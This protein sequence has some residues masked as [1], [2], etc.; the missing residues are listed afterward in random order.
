M[1]TEAFVPDT[2]VRFPQPNVMRRPRAS[3]FSQSSLPSGG[4]FQPARSLSFRSLAAHAQSTT[5]SPRSTLD[6][7]ATGSP[8]PPDIKLFEQLVNISQQ[9]LDTLRNSNIVEKGPNDHQSRFWAVYQKVAA[10]HDDEFFERHDN[11]M[12]IILTFSGLFSAVNTAFITNMGPSNANTTNALLTQIIVLM[13]KESNGTSIGDIYPLP[14][15]PA[16][17]SGQVWFQTLAYASLSFSLLAAFGAVLGK[18]WLRFYKLERCGRGSLVERGKNRQQKLEG[19]EAWHFDAVL[20]MFPVLLQISLLLFGISLSSCVWTQQQTITAIV[21]AT[22]VFGCLFYAFT[23]FASLLSPLCPFQT[24]A[25]FKFLR[26]AGTFIGAG[27]MFIENVAD[28]RHSTRMGLRSFLQSFK[29]SIKTSTSRF[30]QYLLNSK[31]SSDPAT[32]PAVKWVLATSTDPDDIAAAAALIPTITWSPDSNNMSYYQRLRD[33]FVGCFETDGR[34]RPSAEARAVDC[35]RA[36][37]HLCVAGVPIGDESTPRR[38]WHQWRNIVLPQGFEQCKTL[39][40]QLSTSSDR[41]RC[42]ADTRTA[43]RMM[44]AAAGDGFIPPDSE[45]IIWRGRFTWSGDHRTSADF[46]WLV[47]YLV[48]CSKDSTTMADA[49]LAL[50]AMGGLG[51]R[52]RAPAYLEA[53]ISAMKSDSPHRLRYAALRAVSDSR[54]ALADINAIEGEKIRESLLTKLSPALLMA[55]RVENEKNYWRDDAYLRLI[56]A[57]ASNEQ[58]CRQLVADGHIEQCIFMLNNLDERSSA[59]LHLSAVFGRLC[60]TCPDAAAFEAVAHAQFSRLAKLAWQSV[61]D[62]KLYD[63]DESIS[64]LPAVVTFT[65]QK[66]IVADLKDIRRNVGLA[67][68]KLKRRNTRSEIMSVMQDYYTSMLTGLTDSDT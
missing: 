26:M 27:C 59:P 4:P 67:M 20:Q 51:S 50:S 36:L 3:G 14:V 57:L 48:Y 64:A 18:Q 24:P 43:L 33:T 45:S 21:I 58:W 32:E 16:Y 68:D 25:S 15:P 28:L 46:D 40:C 49:F 66:I 11:D 53:L 8:Y 34:L 12:D 63:E 13:A 62:L 2:N 22:T 61:L 17:P 23:L 55:I 38:I 47:D 1:G 5:P 56:M 35:G 7:E 31:P 54:M 39:A 9:V 44:I 52:D 6:T 29:A 30:I 37:N 10:E 60:A 19:L 65:R 42:Q 41:L